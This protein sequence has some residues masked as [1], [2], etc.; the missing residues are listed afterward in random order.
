MQIYVKQL[1]ITSLKLAG[2][3]PESKKKM[4]S[5]KSSS[6]LVWSQNNLLISLRTGPDGRKAFVPNHSNINYKNVKNPLVSIVNSVC[7]SVYKKVVGKLTIV[8]DGRRTSSATYLELVNEWSEDSDGRLHPG[9]GGDWRQSHL[10][11]KSNLII[12]G[13]GFI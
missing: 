5:H 7:N 10:F 13:N 4:F 3:E 12:K 6:H 8:I 2:S 9:D 1:T 11:P